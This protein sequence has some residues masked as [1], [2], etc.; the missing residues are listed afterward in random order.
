MKY[1]NQLI[2]YY[3]IINR[4][5]EN[6][7]PIINIFKKYSF[8]IHLIILYNSINYFKNN[9]VISNILSKIT[10]SPIIKIIVN[11]EINKIENEIYNDLNKPTNKIE[12][13][14]KLTNSK[15]ED[16]IKNLLNKLSNTNNKNN[17]ISGAIYR[18]N[19]ELDKFII[20]IFPHFYGSNALHPNIFPAVKRM[21]SDLVLMV[22]KL[23]NGND[24]C[25]GC[26]TSG[27]TESILMAC[28]AYREWG[29]KKGIKYPEMIVCNSTHSA[30]DKASKY[31]KI[32]LV[33]VSLDIYGKMNILDL[34]KK[35]NKNTVL[36]VTSAP[37]YTHGII[38]NIEE[39]SKIT[40][41]KNIGCHVDCCLGGFILPFIDT[42]FEYDFKLPGVTSISSDFHKY[43]LSPKGI[44]IIM[45]N[46]KELMR[47]QY[48]INPD[49]TGGIYATAT[50]T[51]SRPGNIVAL[52]WAT[53]Q[54]I[55]MDGYTKYA[56]DI[57]TTK[58]Y[59]LNELQKIPE[60][61]IYG[62]PEVCVIGIGSKKFDICLLNDIM[63]EKGWHLNV[64]Q[65]PTSI[66][67]CITHYHTS[68][69]IKNLFIKDIKD[70]IQTIMS[71]N[72]QYESSASIYGTSQ[73]IRNRNLVYQISERYLDCLYK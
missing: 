28:K 42:D 47:N 63:T 71:S 17:K 20:S 41:Q 21:E 39:I 34:K 26:I 48:Y 2:S 55:G 13:I 70:S 59:F 33:R 11:K 29:Y 23:F 44:S 3:Y 65:F 27:G 38:D 37:E 7:S 10:S 66:H 22:I 56:K 4:T 6:K 8:L 73:K 50:M 72:K 1:L 46:S 19:K 30:F 61:F 43:G 60:I 5:F 53:L 24:N 67:L 31:F 68:L 16:E 14:V 45:Y 69:E 35:I 58:N 64:M 57:I 62:N 36:V 49:W 32:K 25:A 52:T 9:P 18:N 12:K 54:Y 40:F 15:N 51:G